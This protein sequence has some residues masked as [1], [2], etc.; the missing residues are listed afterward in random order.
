MTDSSS[1][2]QSPARAVPAESGGINEQ[3]RRGRGAVS[4]R[5]GRFE[6]YVS[7]A[8]DDGWGT[9]DELEA[10]K[11]EVLTERP[12]KI[13]SSNKSPD[14]KFDKSI[15][16]YRGCEHG[17]VYCYAR[18]T[19]TYLGLS[20]GIDFES[21]LFVKENAAKLLEK[22]LAADGYQPQTIAFGANTDAYQPIERQYRVTRSLLEVLD[23]ANHPVSLITKSATIVRDIDILSGM[24]ERGLVK[25]AI[26][27]TTLDRKLAR[28]ME[29]RAS[30]PEKRLEALRLL[31]EAGVP[32]AVVVAPIIPALNDPEIETILKRATAA[33]ATEAGYVV[34]RLPHE[35]RGLFR[36]W[37]QTHYPDREAHVFSLLRSMRDGKEND[38]T[39]GRRMRGSGP[40]AWQLGRRFEIATKRLGLNEHRLNLRTDLF[41]PP[42]MQGQQM[43]LL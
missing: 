4:N 21:K 25:A 17:C 20:A 33:G 41:R 10:F 15:N 14:I 26:S 18:P 43:K 37:L 12:A 30:T 35:L 39:W 31:S 27:I 22:E 32:T 19:H 7:F 29:P 1:I 16:P 13:I 23:R 5:S 42:V 3:R 40:Y 34:L 2:S 9:L 8:S 11:T 28:A 6:S 24:A 36:E 38:S